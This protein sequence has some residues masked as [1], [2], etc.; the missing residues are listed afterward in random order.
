MK[1]ADINR[2]I[3]RAISIGLAASL[4]LVPNVSA[5]ADD[6]DGGGDGGS[7]KKT[8]DSEN[9]EK[10]E[11]KEK[12]DRSERIEHDSDGV[13]ED[14]HE[15]EHHENHEENSH[16]EHNEKPEPQPESSGGNDG[17]GEQAS[18]PADNGGGN[19]G[20]TVVIPGSGETGSE[21]IVIP[22]SGETG[23]AVDG[24]GTP[25]ADLPA[26]DPEKAP[27][28]AQM[29]DAAVILDGIAGQSVKVDDAVSDAA[30]ANEKY[31]GI[32]EQTEGY[33]DSIANGLAIDKNYINNSTA[34]VDASLQNI[35]NDITAAGNTYSD[36]GAAQV[37]K[38]KAE[39]D[40][41]EAINTLKEGEKV[42]SMNLE[43]TEKELEKLQTDITKAET[44]ME[45]ARTKVNTAKAE[46]KK[47]LDDN[48][49]KYNEDTLEVNTDSIDNI[50]DGAIKEA[51]TKAHQAYL[52][53]E[54][55]AGNAQTEYNG[56]CSEATQAMA[57]AY[58][59]VAQKTSA[60][61][62]NLSKTLNEYNDV[63]TQMEEC[64]AAISDKIEKALETKTKD[65]YQ[66]VWDSIRVLAFYTAKSLIIEG[67]SEIDPASIKPASAVY[68]A[69]GNITKVN[70]QN[71]GFYVTYT[72]NG[73]TK[74]VWFNYH[75]V[76]EDGNPIDKDTKLGSYDH[77]TL[78]KDSNSK[79]NENVV[80]VDQANA[81]ES[82]RRLSDSTSESLTA[83]G[84]TVDVAESTRNLL[85]DVIAADTA[86]RDDSASWT[87]Q[88]ARDNAAAAL[89]AYNKLKDLSEFKEQPIIL[90]IDEQQKKLKNLVDNENY[91]NLMNECRKLA[92][93]FIKYN[94]L[95][96]E[97]VNPDSI[98]T[99]HLDWKGGDWEAH[100][101]QV[102]Y[103][104]KDSDD[105]QY[106]YFDYKAY[107]GDELTKLGKDDSK[108][109]TRI[110]V[111]QK[112]VDE[113]GN[114]I[115]T[116]KGDHYYDERDFAGKADEYRTNK[117]NYELNKELFAT[118][119]AY[120]EVVKDK[121]QLVSE[122][123]EA[124]VCAR[125]MMITAG[126]A[127]QKVKDAAQALLDAKIDLNFNE[128]KFNDLKDKYEKA[129]EEN[130]KAKDKL[131]DLKDKLKELDEKINDLD[132]ILKDDSGFKTEKKKDKN[133]NTEPDPE[134]ATSGG[135][136]VT[137]GGGESFDGAPAGGTTTD[138][139]PA[140][141]ISLTAPGETAPGPAVGAAPATGTTPLTGDVL[142]DT[143][144]PSGQVLGERIAPI[145]NAVE[146]GT[147]SR[148][149]LFTEDGLKIPFAWWIIIL[150][151]GAKGV[152]MYTKKKKG[153]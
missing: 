60:E 142:S 153:T 147:F 104:L 41:T 2:N 92:A 58:T 34:A 8:Q 39:T 27:I 29:Y 84:A 76:D 19:E 52:D 128:K 149:M 74:K 56:K 65:D 43:A 97:N 71:G 115:L 67:N 33:V 80:C 70:K 140:E 109:V 46:F 13:K 10:S 48:G 123:K 45:D 127:E 105:T 138:G 30:S 6:G 120:A 26:P 37:A 78:D 82:I 133:R 95:Q 14:S 28:A 121:A 96:D 107:D 79:T 53:A 113:N 98:D 42:A 116:D 64:S 114:L 75:A 20:T 40:L 103:K 125:N 119:L 93:L 83:L 87:A 23:T 3:L 94:L 135:A 85:K 24:T 145:V 146:D 102:T 81:L 106:V 91:G 62:Q 35:N 51:L 137:G 47:L 143:D 73:E 55:K 88:G 36:A 130:E 66:N 32:V 16:E 111:V 59:E 122:F 57:E 9:G 129:K 31:E 110:E 89:E 134:G 144:A 17:G 21:T 131:D 4:V 152:I 148:Q 15:V 54:T 141:G 49:I 77:F 86:V 7:K 44:A 18:A 50:E 150:V 38:D 90:E 117:S 69:D 61:Y 112:K 132:K 139:A 151:L 11:K 100:Y 12:S 72:E 126:D 118:A 99:V 22:G 63:V 68:D 101:G 5:F 108:H 25:A 124:Q 136:A 1:N